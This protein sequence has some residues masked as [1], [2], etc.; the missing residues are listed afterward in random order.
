LG[1]GA[2]NVF[3]RQIRNFIIDMTSVSPTAQVFALH[4]PT[5]QA[6]SVQN[7][8]FKMSDAPG[9]QHQGILSEGGSGGFMTDLTFYGGLNGL[10]IDNQYVQAQ[11]IPIIE[12][13]VA[14]QA[15]RHAESHFLQRSQRDQPR[16]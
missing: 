16:F 11:H 10:N 7:V 9:T 4:W 14:S 1:Y 2:T 3:W 8:V 15:I 13:T 5:A 12:L 6:T